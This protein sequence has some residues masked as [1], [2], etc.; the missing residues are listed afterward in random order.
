MQCNYSSYLWVSWLQAYQKTAQFV[1]FLQRGRIAC[2]VERCNTYSNSVCPSVC[3]SVRLSV[4]HT[5][6]PYLDE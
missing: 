4:C 2:N 5:L 1:A 3:V 6:V